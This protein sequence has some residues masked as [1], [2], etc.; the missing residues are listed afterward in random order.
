MYIL[1]ADDRYT[2]SEVGQS[3]TEFS[4]GPGK[5]SVYRLSA[6]IM[7]ESCKFHGYGKVRIMVITMPMATKG[8][9]VTTREF[10]MIKPF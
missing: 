9:V 6:F 7:L 10:Q 2:L 4:L 8:T 1:R 5:T 3:T